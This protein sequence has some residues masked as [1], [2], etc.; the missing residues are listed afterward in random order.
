MRTGSPPTDRLG[1]RTL[2]AAGVAVAAYALA[3]ILLVVPVE[4]APVQDCGAPGA[5]LLT[6]RLD[7]FIDDQ[8]RFRDA[9]GE[10]IQLTDDQ[11]TAARDGSCRSRVADRAVPAGVLWLGATVLGAGALLIEVFVVRRQL[12]S[13]AC[14]PDEWGTPQEDP[15]D[16][17]DDRP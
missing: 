12:R 15:G 7:T 2:I 16:I 8:G 11:A 5:Y 3:A 13:S 10:I 1:R 6:G 4:N 9:S 17:P 14:P